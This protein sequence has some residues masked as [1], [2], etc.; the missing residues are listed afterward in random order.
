MVKISKELHLT[1]YKIKT[2]E[3]RSYKLSWKFSLF[4]FF[5]TCRSK[6]QGGAEDDE[7]KVP[8]N[9]TC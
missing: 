2:T 9:F 8:D 5:T 7:F 6:A 1:L 3:N 4:G